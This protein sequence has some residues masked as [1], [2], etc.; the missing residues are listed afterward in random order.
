MSER[1]RKTGPAMPGRFA[2]F[3]NY[4]TR[5]RVECI[6]V[7]VQEGG[8]DS[9]GRVL[10]GRH[11]WSRDYES[12]EELTRAALSW[13]RA[14]GARGMAFVKDVLPLEAFGGAPVRALN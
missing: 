4:G 3:A 9:G 7:A 1:V 2:V 13:A 5:E 8:I 12:G 10:D 14:R 11:F 6:A